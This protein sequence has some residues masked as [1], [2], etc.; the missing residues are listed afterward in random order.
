M[1]SWKIYTMFIII[2]VTDVAL[3]L[4]NKKFYF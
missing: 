4:V 1:N 2:V 3:A